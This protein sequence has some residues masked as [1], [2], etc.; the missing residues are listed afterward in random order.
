LEGNRAKMGFITEAF[1]E[2]IKEN[3]VELDAV[4]EKE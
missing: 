3:T 2:E 1:N 4:L